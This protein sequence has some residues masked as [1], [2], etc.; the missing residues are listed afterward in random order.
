LGSIKAANPNDQIP[1]DAEV[2]I[3]NQLIEIQVVLQHATEAEKVEGQKQADQKLASIAQGM[4]AAAFANRLKIAG[5]TADD[6][7]LKLAQDATAQAS[8]TRQLEIHVTDTDAKTWFDAHPGAYDQPVK[9]RVREILLL[10]TSDFTTSAAPP[11]PDAVIQA[12]HQQI[13]DLYKRV[14]AGEDFA[15]LAKQYNEDPISKDN[16]GQLT[17]KREQ[18]G[19]GDLAFSMKTNQ[20]SEVLTNEEGYRFFQ[21]LAIIPAQKAD[22][23]ALADRLKNTLTGM[24]KRTLAPALLEKLRAEAGVEILDAG[25]KAKIAE[26]EAEA[27]ASAKAQAAFEAKQAAAATNAPPAMP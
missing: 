21:L 4:G 13:L 19:F 20:I 11:L 26:A 6:L 9:A 8:L 23:A 25:L 16:G 12:K 15:A 22:F 3:I 2:H 24:R 27:A 1:E 7:R 17:F 5:M 10:T 18:M 14:R